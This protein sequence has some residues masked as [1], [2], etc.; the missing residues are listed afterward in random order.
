MTISGGIKFFEKNKFLFTNGSTAYSMTG[1]NAQYILNNNRNNKWESAG[2]DDST[3]ETLVI[4]LDQEYTIDRL[5]LNGHNFKDVTIYMLTSSFLLLENG[6]N[7]LLESGD[8]LVLEDNLFTEDTWYRFL[9][10]ESATTTSPD[11]LVLDQGGYL[12]LERFTDFSWVPTDPSLQRILTGSNLNSST[13]YFSF[14]STRVRN[15]LIETTTTQIANSDKFLKVLI[16][17]N[18]IGTFVGYP[19][20]SITLNRDVRRFKA[21]SGKAIIQ[22]GFEAVDI[23]LIF[24]DYPGQ[25][26]INVLLSLQDSDDA[27]FVWLCGGREGSDY[28][29]YEV[30]GWDIDDIYFVNLASPLPLS[31]SNGIYLNPYNTTIVLTEVTG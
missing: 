13:T 1:T 25:N 19:K 23:D 24:S 7:L 17:T 16:G 15:I 4:I 21:L 28:F 3:K 6:D 22:K 26:D 9:A 29:T 8:R 20:S 31:F 27:F 12:K 30:R 2:S 5:I 18:E 10:L 11:L 14:D